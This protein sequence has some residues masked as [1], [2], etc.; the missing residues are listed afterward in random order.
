MSAERITILLLVLAISL[1]AVDETICQSQAPLAW[2]CDNLRPDSCRSPAWE[3]LGPFGTTVYDMSYHPVQSGLVYAATLEGFYSSVDGGL[4]WIERLPAVATHVRIDPANPSTILVVAQDSSNRYL[5]RST[6]WG[7]NWNAVFVENKADFDSIAF[8]TGRPGVAYMTTSWGYESYKECWFY[9][10]TDGGATW[11][12]V[13]NSKRPGI[14]GFDDLLIYPVDG[15]IL[16]A[17]DHGYYQS[18]IVQSTDGGATWSD[19]SPGL[20]WVGSFNDL[21]WISPGMACAATS[22]GLFV[23]SVGTA[24]WRQIPNALVGINCEM[25]TKGPAD[26]IWYLL[27]VPIW[28]ER[29]FLYRSDDFG[30]SWTS[31]GDIEGHE[32]VRAL[33]VNPHDPPGAETVMAGL[34]DTGVLATDDLGSTWVMRNSNDW[35]GIDCVSL[36]FGPPGSGLLYAGGSHMIWAPAF[37]RSRDLGQTWEIAN[38]GLPGQSGIYDI[39]AHPTDDQIVFAAC[40]WAGLFR[41]TDQGETWTHLDVLHCGTPPYPDTSVRTLEIDQNGFVYAGLDG[42]LFRSVDT[43]QTWTF[44]GVGMGRS[45][46]QDLAV[47]P[48]NSL[49]MFAAYHCG[50]DSGIYES[51]DGGSSWQ[52]ILFGLNPWD[53]FESVA[54]APG[55]GLVYTSLSWDL[56]RSKDGGTTWGLLPEPGAMSVVVPP[57]NPRVVV[58]AGRDVWI[59][60]DEGDSWFTLTGLPGGL[61]FFIEDLGVPPA[62]SGNELLYAAT[63]EGIF[64]LK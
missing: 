36:A 61:S 49:Q 6:D 4:T 60:L 23:S 51:I 24:V 11:T 27:D 62:G 18:R 19:A 8:D 50:D 1:G 46:V 37:Y 48:L 10:S 5:M 54:V 34:D 53:D 16:A 26:N 45:F 17:V 29:I 31:L 15:R 57:S 42:G 20:G 58:C 2:S 12:L 56:Y 28:T 13:F 43:G 33:A 22:E 52:R 44:H 21:E 3:C 39:A 30:A 55:G 63:R 25:L 40:N 41:S 59:S 35:P 47:D 9:R 32:W 7:Q 38:D 14:C 64:H